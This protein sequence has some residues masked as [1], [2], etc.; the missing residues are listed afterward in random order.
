M[1]N[2]SYQILDTQLEETLTDFA[3][4]A[5]HICDA[6]TAFI[7]L[8]DAQKQW[9]KSTTNQDNKQISRDIAFC[10]YTSLH[11]REILLIND[12][13]N[14]QRFNHNSLV[15][16]PPYI[17]FYV[18]FPLL[19]KTG[20]HL[21]NLSIIDYQPK[22][23]SIS[24]LQ[25]LQNLV[26][27]VIK[28]LE[29]STNF[30]LIRYNNNQHKHI[31]ENLKFR[32]NQQAVVATLGQYALTGVNL[33]KLIN[34]AVALVAENLQV[35]YCHILEYR[36]EN[37]NFIIKAGMGWQANIINN[38]LLS[39]GHTSQAGYTLICGEPIIVEDLAYEQRFTGNSLL[40]AEGIVSGITVI[41]H[42][43]KNPFGILGTHTKRKRK[44]S[45]NDVNFLQAVAN[46]LATAIER[47]NSEIALE[48]AKNELEIR[49]ENRTAEL[50]NLNQR[51]Q[52]EL[53]ER[54]QVEQALREAKARF[55][56][57]IEI[58]DDAI[59]SVNSQQQITLFNKG[60]EKIF[61]YH[62]GEIL[63]KNIE[64]LLPKRFICPHRQHVANFGKANGNARKMGERQ[65]IFGIRKN[66]SEFPA[67]ASISQ[68]EVAGEKIFTAI[69]R[70]ISEQQAGLRER[71]EAEEA[72]ASLSRK[73]ELI[74]NS[75]GEGIFG[76]NLQANITFVNPAAARLLG[77]QVPELLNKSIDLILED[78]IN[79]TPISASLEQGISVQVTEQLFK[80]K[81]G[82]FFSVEYIITPIVE[83][84]IMGVVIAF[85]DIT[86]RHKV[87]RMKNE[88]ISIVSH[89][90]RT[91]LTSIYGSLTMLASG[92]L[93]TDV[94]SSNRLLTIAVNST[95]RL[96]R[97]INDILDIERIESGKIVMVKA[98]N[99]VA[100]MMTKAVETIQ[101]FA[102]KYSVKISAET[103]VDEVYAD[104]D[105]IIQTLTNLLS[106]AIKFS[107]QNG[108]VWLTASKQEHEILFQVRDE[109]RGI[110]EDKLETIFEKF[111]Q[112]DFSDSRNHEGTGL[113]LA[114]CR[115]IVQQ[116]HG[117]IW[118][119]SDLGQG[120]V[121]YFT[122]P[123]NET[124]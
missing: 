119:E 98:H 20:K 82:S 30:A 13:L 66:G 68:L 31:E 41:I 79:K 95:E 27:Q 14:D 64:L 9:F 59:I 36:P 109:G 37:N 117:K 23:L 51:L 19:S 108:H 58:A 102:D 60:A 78:H 65:E 72:L 16:S 122:L 99:S 24:Q 84:E 56:G 53:L 73:N 83:Q 94:E 111:Q 44:F 43:Q 46:I 123:I 54:K 12:T 115:S 71:K 75:A 1:I 29:I 110:P 22:E 34:D 28:Q 38:C 50:T 48:Y 87:E 6:S 121:F 5:A 77:Y 52:L 91:P 57:I 90:L 40:L 80:R 21:G 74:L 114:I 100:D 93:A 2:N 92:L 70:D 63:G 86:E 26:K 106:N 76:L 67:E 81:D 97:L 85:K 3:N 89:E 124:N 15:I 96:V 47:K 4:L 18:G 103:I 69:L 11:F 118:V 49:V 61:G 7:G 10:A 17:R 45:Q 33:N 104:S 116:H 88:F 55:S 112:V 25:A 120:S 62:A 39:G 35:E 107:P 42:G 32:L 101:S 113:G 105:R 8:L